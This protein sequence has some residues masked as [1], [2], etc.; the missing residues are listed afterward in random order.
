MLRALTLAALLASPAHADCVVLLHGLARSDTSLILMAQ[1][2]NNAGFRTVNQAYPSTSAAIPDLASFVGEGIASCALKPDEQVHFVTH[3]MGGILVRHYLTD[4]RPEALGRVV[5]LAPPNQGSE[6]VD[7][8]SDTAPFD[9]V[10]GPAGA[11]LGTDPGSIPLNLP[12]PDYPL[13]IIA[14]NQSLN[15]VYS[16]LIPG[17][18]DGKVS[19]AS[20]KVDGMTAHLTLPATHTFLMM[21]PVAMRE[22]ILFLQTGAFDPALTYAR[23][24]EDLLSQ[25]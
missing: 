19:V 5:M 21:N 16:S 17:P 11:Q 7:A 3:S 20:T 9:W 4:H 23:A 22:T 10:N 1:A 25:N 14:G 15:P 6:L 18:D 13:G 12:R 8:L 24:V 2:L